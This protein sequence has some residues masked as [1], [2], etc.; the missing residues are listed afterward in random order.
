MSDYAKVV[1]PTSAATVNARN[2]QRWGRSKDNTATEA[3]EGI[4][5][6]LEE[7]AKEPEHQKDSQDSCPHC[8]KKLHP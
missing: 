2:A 6:F 7:E 5:K 1:G 3:K 8:G 4:D